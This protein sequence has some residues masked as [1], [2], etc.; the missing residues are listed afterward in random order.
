M[1]AGLEPVA[2]A[3]ACPLATWPAPGLSLPSCLSSLPS[4]GG[5]GEPVGRA[6]F[7]LSGVP[8]AAAAGAAGGDEAVARGFTPRFTVFTGIRVLVRIALRRAEM[9]QVC[10]RTEHCSKIRAHARGPG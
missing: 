2:E 7:S 9:Q 5:P 10:D 3:A 8:T 6:A 4:G 1:P